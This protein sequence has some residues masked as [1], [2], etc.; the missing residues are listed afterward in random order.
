MFHVEHFLASSAGSLFQKNVPRGTLSRK[1][2]ALLE[3]RNL[4]VH[5]GAE[6]GALT[7]F[8]QLYSVQKLAALEWRSSAGI[9]ARQGVL[10]CL[11]N[12]KVT[13]SAS[14]LKVSLQN[15]GAGPP[16]KGEGRKRSKP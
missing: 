13:L 16:G 10:L 6:L 12:V 2:C 14:A 8:L 9:W 15:V 11:D 5:V 1:P 4:G 3:L 7:S